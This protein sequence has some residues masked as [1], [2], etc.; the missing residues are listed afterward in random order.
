LLPKEKV[1][2]GDKSVHPP[3]KFSSEVLFIEMI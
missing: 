2:H 3:N 1:H